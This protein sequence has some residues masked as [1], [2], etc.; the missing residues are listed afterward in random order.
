MCLCM[1]LDLPESEGKRFYALGSV[2]SSIRCFPTILGNRSL[3]F[4]EIWHESSLIWFLKSDGAP[5]SKKII[6]VHN[7]H[8]KRYFLPFFTVFKHFSVSTR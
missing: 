7:S 6:S 8:L 2:R 5:F 3:D 4:S 1:F